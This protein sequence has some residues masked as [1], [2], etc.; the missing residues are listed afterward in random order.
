MQNEIVII[1][2]Q[3]VTAATSKLLTIAN[4]TAFAAFDA[5]S[6]I[7]ADDSNPDTTQTGVSRDIIN[8]QPLFV[9]NPVFSKFV[10]TKA[11]EFLYSLGVAAAREMMSASSMTSCTMI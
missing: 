8:A 10:K 7:V 5:S 6:A 11:A 4:G 9:Q 2:A 3:P 1:T